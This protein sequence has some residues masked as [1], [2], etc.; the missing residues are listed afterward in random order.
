M[1]YVNPL[2]NLGAYTNAEDLQKALGTFP[3]AGN[4]P[5]E[6]ADNEND[7]SVDITTFQSLLNRLEGSKTRQQR[8]QSV[9]GRRDIYAQGLSSMMKN[10]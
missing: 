7:A 6:S 3:E 9:E 10:F 5:G 2:A 1:Q 4:D 8:Q